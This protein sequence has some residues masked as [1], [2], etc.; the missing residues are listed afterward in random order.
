MFW[1]S[2]GPPGR[3]F[4]FGYNVVVLLGLIVVGLLYMRRPDLFTWL[5]SVDWRKA[6]VHGVWFAMLGGV[7]IS[8]KGIYDHRLDSEWTG[9]GWTLWYLGRPLSAAIVGIMTYLLLQVANT[10]SSPTIPTLAV[11]A[12]VL[13]TQEKRFFT[14]VYDVGGLVL[15]VPEKS[16]SL[17]LKDIQPR[18]GKEGEVVVASG[19]AIAQGATLSVGGRPL[20]DVHV[21]ADGTAAAGQLPIKPAEPGPYD[22]VVANPD[23]TAFRWPRIFDYA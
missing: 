2:W 13:G 4:A 7:A 10:S 15:T 20:A 23:G 11:A 12:F 16:G 5:T 22:I 19:Q 21:S 1:T 6:A 17:S 18:T 9:G 8:L 14:F 3:R